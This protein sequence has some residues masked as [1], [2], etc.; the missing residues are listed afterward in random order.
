MMKNIWTIK[1]IMAADL[2][3]QQSGGDWQSTGPHLKLVVV[4]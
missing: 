2:E 3:V 4:I 1:L